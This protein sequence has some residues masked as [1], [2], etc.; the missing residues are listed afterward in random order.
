MIKQ[1]IILS[2]LLFFLSESL[3]AQRT[4]TRTRNRAPEATQVPVNQ[5]LWYGAYLGNFGFG[6]GGFSFSA[7]GSAAYK[8]A[9]PLSAGLSTKFFY[10]T[11]SVPA[12]PDISLFSY[13]AGLFARVK[14]IQSVFLQGE[15]NLT[16]YDSDG[17]FS[18]VNPGRK[19]FTYPMLGGGYESGYGPWTYGI[20]LLFNLDEDVRE[21]GANDFGEYWLTFSYNF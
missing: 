4:R 2:F 9:G 14:V 19:T 1:A 6:N 12:A 3:N 5:K 11:I 15:Y 17:A 18:N 7:K 16:S 13:G 20:M 8:F 21:F 10:N